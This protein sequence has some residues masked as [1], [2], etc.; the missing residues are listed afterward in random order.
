MYFV[1]AKFP[2]LR[3]KIDLNLKTI[4]NNLGPT[5]TTLQFVNEYCKTRAV[6]G[7]ILTLEEECIDWIQQYYLPYKFDSVTSSL[8][9]GEVILKYGKYD[10]VWRNNRMIGQFRTKLPK[11]R[12]SL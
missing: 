7:E 2:D 8:K 3:S 10:K 11:K 4:V 1:M 5:F 12:V 6:K 9:T